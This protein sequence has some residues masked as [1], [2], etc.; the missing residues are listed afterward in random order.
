M[1]VIYVLHV[2]YD[3]SSIFNKYS[4][5]ATFS[6]SNSGKYHLNVLSLAFSN[7]IQELTF[8]I[9]EFSEKNTQLTNYKFKQ[10]MRS[11]LFDQDA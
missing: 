4:C 11:F 6:L 8:G 10:E 7:M 3:F 9:S 5:I 2:C 1:I